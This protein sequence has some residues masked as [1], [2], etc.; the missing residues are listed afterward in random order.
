M[1]F[2]VGN[3]CLVAQSM[4]AVHPFP[5]WEDQWDLE[6]ESAVLI[7]GSGPKALPG[8]VA[9]GDAGFLLCSVT[10]SRQG[11][12]LKCLG[13]V[14]NVSSPTLMRYHFEC[15]LHDWKSTYHHNEG[16]SREQPVERGV[17]SQSLFLHVCT[18][19]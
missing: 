15:Y 12:R 14:T 10:V 7:A 5:F 18:W 6:D 8:W 9:N 11:V 3:Q 13:I 19:L 4:I 2:P 16:L 17:A 1:T